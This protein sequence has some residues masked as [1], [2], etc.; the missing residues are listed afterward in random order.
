M[1]AE[2]LTFPGSKWYFRPHLITHLY[3]SSLGSPRTVVTSPAG[4][5]RVC[6]GR[7]VP[8]DGKAPV[9]SLLEG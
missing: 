1:V 7:Y 6:W 4:A 3:Y 9:A 2:H 5:Q 8:A